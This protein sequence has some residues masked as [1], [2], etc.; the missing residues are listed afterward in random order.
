MWSTA[1]TA[2]ADA[3]ADFARYLHGQSTDNMLELRY[4]DRRRVHNL[5]YFTWVEQQGKSY[6]EI[7]EMWNR[8]DYWTE[9]QGQVGEIDA[10]IEEFNREGRDRR[11]KPGCR[12]GKPISSWYAWCRRHAI[13]R[14]RGCSAGTASLSGQRPRW[15]RSTNWPSISRPAS[16]RPGGRI[17]FTAPVRG[18]E[19]TTRAELFKDEVGHPR[20]REEYFRIQIGALEPLKQPIA[21][22]KWRR[23]T[24]LYTTGEYLLRAQSLHDLVVRD[25]ER[26]LLWRALRDRARRLPDLSGRPSGGRCSAGC[27]A[28]FARASGK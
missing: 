15:S 16:A 4:P 18:H 12:S 20:A 9:V 26:A 2:P 14:S 11:S 25:D 6:E 10:L 19:L 21:A 17:D 27:A 1:S 24:F 22:D 28:G 7:Q 5:K 8:S 13:S 23:I 3:A